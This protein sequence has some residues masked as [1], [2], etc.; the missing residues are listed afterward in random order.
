M[1]IAP[2]IMDINTDTTSNTHV[3][4]S[5]TIGEQGVQL[6]ETGVQLAETGVHQPLNE[7]I[8]T[9]LPVHSD[10]VPSPILPTPST[11]IYRNDTDHYRMYDPATSTGKKLQKYFPYIGKT[12]LDSETNESFT[13]TAVCRSPDS[14][15]PYF[16][17]YDHIQ[18][19]TAPA[20]EE[21]YEFTPCTEIL[22][23]ADYKFNYPIHHIRATTTSISDYSLPDTPMTVKMIYS[24]KHSTLLQE[25]LNK[26]LQSYVTN[27]AITASTLTPAAIKAAGYQLLSVRIIFSIKLHP[28][29]TFNKYKVRMVLR[30]DR[31]QNLANIDL[32]ASTVRMDSLR[33]IWSLICHYN[34]E[35]AFFDVATAF[36]VPPLRVD[37]HIYI[38]RPSSLDDSHMPAISKVNKCIYGLPQAAKYFEEDLNAK[39]ASLNFTPL[40]CDPKIF[41]R[42]TGES[43]V[44]VGTHVDDNMVAATS[45]ALRDEFLREIGDL[46]TITTVIDPTMFLG[47][48][49]SRDRER[50]T[51]EISQPQYIQSLLEKHDIPL[52]EKNPPSTP[53]V[54]IDTDPTSPVIPSPYLPI[55]AI[56]TYQSRIGGLLY[57]AIM[58]R[59]DILYAVI[60]LS[61]H[62]QSPTEHDMAAVERLLRY[63][64]GTIDLTMKYNKSTS[65]DLQLSAYADASYNVHHDNK[66]HS[67]LLVCL[68]TYSAP[69]L[70]SSKKQTI[71]ADSSTVAELIAAHAVT[72]E[73]QWTINMLQELGFSLPTTPILHQ[74]NMS[75]IKI[76]HQPGNSGKT[77]HISLR[78]NIVRELCANGIIKVQYLATE[79]MIADILT[80]ALGPTAFLHL[81][82]LLMGH[83]NGNTTTSAV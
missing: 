32:Y 6:A 49:I 69:L 79:E 44:I 39:M 7:I 16:K 19:P 23:V 78:Y 82:P 73:L 62:T 76:V 15:R 33:L 11:Y 51:L 34:L 3:T 67:G 53:M 27:G 63:V 26:E 65:S 70:Y 28:D 37:E 50:N 14:T 77:K 2:E 25:A 13:I 52:V 57:L 12:F 42:R 60:T 61:Q 31:W 17:F 48:T 64:A 56:T 4:R 40:V 43:F 36:L 24:H 83:G 71:T 59:P 22:S 66:S 55:S 81:R 74:D 30:G 35:L 72:K 9:I 68:G 20:L 10:T 46:Y 38:K 41:I 58:T 45:V 18:Y 29:G 8:P 75:T 54:C 1:L 47:I 21:N 5:T 80:K